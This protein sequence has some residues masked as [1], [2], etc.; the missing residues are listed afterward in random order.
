MFGIT[1]DVKFPTHEYPFLD[2]KDEI[3]PF[4]SQEKHILKNMRNAR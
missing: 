3:Y 2:G 1:D 4:Q